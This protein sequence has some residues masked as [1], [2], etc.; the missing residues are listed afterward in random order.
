MAGQRQPVELL[1]AKGKKHLTK[2]EI[3]KRKQKEL[4]IESKEIVVP[5]YLPESL[6]QEFHETAKRLSEIELFTDLD[7]DGLARYLLSKQVYLTYT[8]KL[9]RASKGEDIS[10]IAKLSTIQDKAYKQCRSAANDLGLSITSRCKL[11]IPRKEET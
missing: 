11:T 5:D 2:A 4:K 8:Q 9:A 1:Q 10:L 3:E 7:V 6:K